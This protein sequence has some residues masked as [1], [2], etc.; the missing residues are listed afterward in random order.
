[1]IYSG[2]GDIP[3]HLYCWVDSSFVR[4]D[5]VGYEPCVWFGL[6]SFPGRAWGCHVMLECGAVYR[7]LPPHALAFRPDPAEPWDIDNAEVWD[8]YGTQFSTIEYAFLTGLRVG[9]RKHGDGR[10]LFTAIPLGDGYSAEPTQSK[11]F[12]FCHLDNGRLAILPTNMVLFDD[13]SFTEPDWPDDMRL[14]DQVWRA[15]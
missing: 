2:S 11:E 6:H 9:T 15:E 13:P 12:M 8:C 14:T 4:K 3:R 10:Y 5:A 7:G 1:M